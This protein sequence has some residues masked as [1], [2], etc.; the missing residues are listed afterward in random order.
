MGLWI[1]LSA[2]LNPIL[3]FI[4]SE[5]SLCTEICGAFLPTSAGYWCVCLSDVELPQL[6]AL[7]RSRYAPVGAQDVTSSLAVPL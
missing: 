5:L 2:D 7:G 3:A 6:S 1:V 4:L